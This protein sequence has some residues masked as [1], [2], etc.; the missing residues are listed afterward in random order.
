MFIISDEA[1]TDI[2]AIPQHIAMNILT[3][4]HRLAESNS[5]DVKTLKG[6]AGEKRLRVGEHRVLTVIRKRKNLSICPRSRM[7]G[8]KSSL[9]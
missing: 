5:G 4:I 1:K 2:R 8:F 7:P 9:G 3:A 6:N